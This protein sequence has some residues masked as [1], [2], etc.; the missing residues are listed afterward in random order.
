MA[1]FFDLLFP[2]PFPFPFPFAVDRRPLLDAFASSPR[3]DR[4]SAPNRAS[5][6]PD[7]SESPSSLA[8]ATTRRV[9]LET[10]AGD[11]DAAAI[12]IAR[13]DAVDAERARDATPRGATGTRAPR[14]MDAIAFDA[15]PARR[16]K[17]S[18][19]A[20]AWE[21]MRCEPRDAGGGEMD[22][23]AARAKRRARDVTTRE[24]V[25]DDITR[26]DTRWAR[27]GGDRA[28]N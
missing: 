19:D 5:L 8:R 15:R 16:V 28:Y 27:A 26:T 4:L 3:V 14:A 11:V 2:F 25:E 6:A 24:R 12:V 1:D 17:T 10:R 20:R 22:G 9:R 21:R 23:A 18:I 13:G 7:A